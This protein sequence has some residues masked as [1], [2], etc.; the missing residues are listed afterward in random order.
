M[1][2]ACEVCGNS[3]DKM[4]TVFIDSKKHKFDC[5]ECAIHALAPSCSHCGIRIM[6]HGLEEGGN[7]FCCAHC[8]RASGHHHFTD[9]F[10]EV[11]MP[12]K[13]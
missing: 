7:F 8:A 9:R 2:E 4:M 5:F 10:E 13:V 12:E 3:Y 1:K 11:R 6:G